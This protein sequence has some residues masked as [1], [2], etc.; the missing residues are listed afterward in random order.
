MCFMAYSLL[1][2]FIGHVR[3]VLN[4]TVE[5]T[6]IINFQYGDINNSRQV[7]FLTWN[8]VQEMLISDF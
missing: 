1:K 2:R 5:A 7:N 8:I 4:Y 6:N 3:K